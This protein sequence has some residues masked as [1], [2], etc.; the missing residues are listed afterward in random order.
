MSCQVYYF[1]GHEINV[2]FL[3]NTKNLELDAKIV[4]VF[5]GDVQV[6]NERLEN[7][8]KKINNRCNWS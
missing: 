2:Q 7:K 6:K 1:E 3:I 4:S 8:F 5:K